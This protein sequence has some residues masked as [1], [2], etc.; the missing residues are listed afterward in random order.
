MG[1]ADLK[2]IKSDLFFVSFLRNKMSRKTR[3]FLKD[4]DD[5][6][7]KQSEKNV[8]ECS[9]FYVVKHIDKRILKCKSDN[10]YFSPSTQKYYSRCLN[11]RNKCVKHKEID[12]NIPKDMKKVVNYNPESEKSQ[13]RIVLTDRMRESIKNILKN[14]K[15]RPNDVEILTQKEDGDIITQ[16]E[17]EDI[18]SDEDDDYE[19]ECESLGYYE[20]EEYFLSGGEN[21]VKLDKEG[22]G[23]IVGKKGDDLYKKILGKLHNPW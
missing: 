5:K 21:I 6:L 2:I 19:E 1:I 17:K 3:K 11:V 22:Y 16:K 9:C 8:E 4:L 10:L 14:D 12:V 15:I 23:E 13:L 20:G 7:F 18:S